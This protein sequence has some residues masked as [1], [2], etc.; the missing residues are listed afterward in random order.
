MKSKW[1][2][3]RAPI[4]LGCKKS[5]PVA[6]ASC[7]NWCRNQFSMLNNL[8]REENYKIWAYPKNPQV[9]ILLDNV[10]ISGLRSI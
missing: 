3:I 5:K 2:K 6:D 10:C 8:A 7:T 4:N 9:A 1:V